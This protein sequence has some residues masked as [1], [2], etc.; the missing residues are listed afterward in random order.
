MR[1]ELLPAPLRMLRARRVE[2][3]L[4][5]TDLANKFGLSKQ[6]LCEIE[7]GNQRPSRPTLIMLCDAL[8]LPRNERQR[9]FRFFEHKPESDTDRLAL[10]LRKLR[11]Q[12]GYSQIEMA[13]KIGTTRASIGRAEAGRL[14]AR[15]LSD[16]IYNHFNVAEEERIRIDEDYQYQTPEDFCDPVSEGQ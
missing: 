16:R 7:N 14:A 13:E 8:N 1:K 10:H 6:S 5:Q 2:I 9:I 3:Q 15:Y 4:S 12:A 11:L